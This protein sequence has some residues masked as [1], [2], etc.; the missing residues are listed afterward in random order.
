MAT[1]VPLQVLDKFLLQYDVGQAVLLLFVLVVVGSVP[2]GSRRVLA[3][4]V[5]LF[6]VLFALLPTQ[7]APFAYRILGVVLLVVAPMLWVSAR[8]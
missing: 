2:L 4:N 3:L 8:E 1:L 6:G 5:G 7:L